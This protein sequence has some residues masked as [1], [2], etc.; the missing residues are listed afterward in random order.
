M[1][2]KEIIIV[3][4]IVIIAIVPIF[5]INSNTSNQK[6]VQLSI[7]NEPYKDILFDE[8][9]KETYTVETDDGYNTILIENGTIKVI[10]ANCPNQ[11]CVHTKAISESG[12]MIVCLP[13]KLVVEIT[14]QGRWKHE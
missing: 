2:K 6:N 3:A 5:L 13:H 4:L 10:E 1:K 11:V 8:S 7:D 9:T 14:E 12:E